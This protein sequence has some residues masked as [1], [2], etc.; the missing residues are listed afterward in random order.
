[1]VN[2]V[3]MAI[4]RNLGN[5]HLFVKSQCRPK[6]QELTPNGSS[7]VNHSVS[8]LNG[9]LKSGVTTSAVAS[10]L[11]MLSDSEASGSKEKGRIS[12]PNISVKSTSFSSSLLRASHNNSEYECTYYKCTTYMILHLYRNSLLGNCR[13]PS[14]MFY[15]PCNLQT[16]WTQLQSHRLNPDLVNP[17]IRTPFFLVRIPFIRI[18]RL[19]IAEN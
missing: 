17:D 12:F 8:K 13:K 10:S 15:T 11:S 3:V 7:H 1:M 4:F 6:T 19:K 18:S 14:R 2:T 16:L 5:K 9:Y